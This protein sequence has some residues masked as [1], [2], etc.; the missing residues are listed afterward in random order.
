MR[1]QF[2]MQEQHFKEYLTKNTIEIHK[3]AQYIS[4]K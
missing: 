1:I 2:K 4:K 3:K